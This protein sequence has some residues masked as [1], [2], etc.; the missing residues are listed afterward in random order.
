[1][2][3]RQVKSLFDFSGR[4]ET[5][6]GAGRRSWTLEKRKCFDQRRGAKDEAA[7]KAPRS[8]QHLVPAES[9]PTEDG[10]LKI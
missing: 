8:G 1:M 2:E 3:V 9:K 10:Y 4:T 6:R 5:S 7:G